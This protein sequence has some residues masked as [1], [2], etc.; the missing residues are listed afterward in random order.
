MVEIREVQT[1]LGNG[2]IEDCGVKNATLCKGYKL[3][4]MLEIRVCWHFVRAE[5]DP[6]GGRGTE[7]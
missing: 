2:Q 3:Q 7:G 1:I 6:R 5:E 4:A